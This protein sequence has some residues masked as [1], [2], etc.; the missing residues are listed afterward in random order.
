MLRSLERLTQLTALVPH[1]MRAKVPVGAINVSVLADPLGQ[2]ED[3]G[4]WDY[5]LTRQLEQTAPSI[6]LNVGCIYD[7]QIPEGLSLPG[8]VV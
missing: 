2:I 1:D 4:H 3:N 5:M 8:D 7:N 6:L